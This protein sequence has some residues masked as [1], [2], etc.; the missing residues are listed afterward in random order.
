MTQLSTQPLLDFIPT[1]SPD[2]VPPYHLAPLPQLLELADGGSARVLASP[3][4][5]HGKTTLCQHAIARMFL[6]NPKLEVFYLSH[7]AR[8]AERN[9]REIRRL[10]LAAGEIEPGAFEFDPKHNTIQEWR[11]TAGGTFYAAS[12]DQEVIGRGADV[13]VADDPLAWQDRASPD[14]REFVDETLSF[15][16]T[17][18]N[19]GGSVFIIMSRMHPDDP[20]GRRMTGRARN[21]TLVEAPGIIDEGLPTE[22]AL[23]P[24]GKT[25]EELKAIRTE[26]CERGDSRVWESQYQGRPRAAVDDLFRE[27]ARYGQLP[28]WPG[29]R[30]VIGVDLAYTAGKDSDWFAAVVLKVYGDKAYV[31]EVTR[32]HVVVPEIERELRRLSSQYGQAPIFSYVSGPERGVID[33]FAMR[34]IFV[35]PMHARWGKFDRAQHTIDAHNSGRLL[36][37]MTAPWLDGALSRLR[38]FDGN[39]NGRDDDEVDALVSAF[40]GGVRGGL[41]APTRTL[42]RA[43]M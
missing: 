38:N 23:W 28:D 21:W 32:L 9:S 26:L 22:R 19:R 18:L 8:F 35:Q 34:G 16:T 13:I 17:R 4:V 29:F 20:I 2:K 12:C 10:L 15:L 42:G 37:P 31:A 7:A 39:Q 11:S 6:R 36:W 41:T 3:C 24:E 30:Y 27:P 43:R 1:L 33:F 40:D 14:K 25:L 5:R